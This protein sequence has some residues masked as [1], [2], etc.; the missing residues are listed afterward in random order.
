[1][2]E[3][4]FLRPLTGAYQRGAAMI[5]VA[6]KGDHAITLT[7]PGQ[8]AYELEPVRGKR[9]NIKGQNGSSVDFKGEDLVFYQPNGVSVATRKN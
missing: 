9:F 5:T 8:E 4:T 7:V 6:M 3:T 1:M 2:R